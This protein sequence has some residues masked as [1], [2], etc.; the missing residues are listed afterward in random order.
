MVGDGSLQSGF[1]DMHDLDQDA[2]ERGELPRRTIIEPAGAS[3]L[4]DN[5][6]GQWKP[7]ALD[8][9]DDPRVTAEMGNAGQGPHVPRRVTLDARTGASVTS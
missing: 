3:R 7:L 8:G 6:A 4:S 9:R 1:A 5:P 2:S